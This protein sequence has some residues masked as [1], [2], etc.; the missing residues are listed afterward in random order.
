MIVILRK[1]TSLDPQKLDFEI[2]GILSKFYNP[3]S[4]CT[5]YFQIPS[6]RT[7]IPVHLNQKFPIS[8]QK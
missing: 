4:K 2:M 5:S 8:Q 1:R 3:R 6:I 7:L